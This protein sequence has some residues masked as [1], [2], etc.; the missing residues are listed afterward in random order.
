MHRDRMAK[1]RSLTQRYRR[2]LVVLAGVLLMGSLM[3]CQP[4][5]MTMDLEG[6]TLNASGQAM[7]QAIEEY[8][9]SALESYCYPSLGPWMDINRTSCIQGT[10]DGDLMVV[11]LDERGEL[12]WRSV[13]YVYPFYE[14][15]A[16]SEGSSEAE[17]PLMVAPLI[18]SPDG[19]AVAYQSLHSQGRF[20]EIAEMGKTTV[21]IGSD[22]QVYATNPELEE[23][24]AVSWNLVK[25]DWSSDGRYLLF[26]R[27]N[28]WQVGADDGD[29]D[30]E[31]DLEMDREEGNKV[32]KGT[33]NQNQA[34]VVLTIKD[35]YGYD[36]QTC[37]VRKFWEAMKL[38]LP[39]SKVPD[40][41]IVA[42]IFED[43]AAMF[44]LFDQKAECP[45]VKIWNQNGVL[46]FELVELPDNPCIQMDPG[47]AVYYYQEAGDIWKSSLKKHGQPQRLLTAGAQLKA[48]LISEDEHR[49]F[50]IESREETEDV[51][52]YLQDEKGSWYRQVIA[53]GTQGACALQLSDDQQ[54]LLVECRSKDENCAVVIYFGQ[55]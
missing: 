54:R 41:E 27:T 36:R 22:G 14:G 17:D 24:E 44:L 1:K 25:A 3:A 11:T 20:L 34:G 33:G 50:T 23:G 15:R 45:D 43:S 35:I 7:I 49:I 31:V 29:I 16:L 18:V 37:Q 6:M 52:L 42:D 4:Q 51:C 21:L 53:V 9:A 30:L 38:N 48:F 47:Q 2:W 8:Q 13:Q 32:Q 26:Y 55:Q 28:N 12:E 39:T 46:E 19:L 5:S 10:D 40:Y